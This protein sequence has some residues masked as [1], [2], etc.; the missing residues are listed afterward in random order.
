MGVEYDPGVL[1]GFKTENTQITCEGFQSYP[2]CSCCYPDGHVFGEEVCFEGL[3]E[4]KFQMDDT[5]F[6]ELMRKYFGIECDYYLVQAGDACFYHCDARKISFLSWIREEKPEW[7]LKKCKRVHK[8]SLDLNAIP[9]IKMPLMKKK[10]WMRVQKRVIRK[11]KKIK[12]NARL[13]LCKRM[14][15]LMMTAKKRRMAKGKS[16]RVVMRLTLSIQ[17]L[18]SSKGI[19]NS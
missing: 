15:R 9:M 11:S 16:R 3:K 12:M 1:Y 2:F 18:N 14:Q 7:S 13:N 8:E 17:S 5:V 10:A 19:N 4:S 6:G